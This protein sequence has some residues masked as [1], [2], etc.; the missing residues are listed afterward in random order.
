MY[1]SPQNQLNINIC[2]RASKIYFL[3]MSGKY[4]QCAIFGKENL[5]F[6]D[7]Y[8]RGLMS[9]G[10]IG[11]FWN[12]FLSHEGKK[13]HGIVGLGWKYQ[14][15]TVLCMIIESQST[16]PIWYFLPKSTGA[17]AS[18]TPNLTTSRLCLKS[19]LYILIAFKNFYFTCI[20][21]S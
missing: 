10:F 20:A 4:C 6:E 19:K 3:N 21:P 7:Y 12:Q 15:Y 14:K 11:L 9:D 17:I 1:K 18:F 5:F 16:R 2:Y 8:F 13:V